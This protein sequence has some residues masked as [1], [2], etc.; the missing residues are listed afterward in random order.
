MNT[1]ATAAAPVATCTGAAIL[2]DHL[3]WSGVQTYSQCAPRPERAMLALMQSRRAIIGYKDGKPE[4]YCLLLQGTEARPG[5]I[6]GAVERETTFR[7]AYGLFPAIRKHWKPDGT[8][9][10]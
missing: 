5:K 6:Q 9:K 10:D 2:P 1:T 7:E 8:A 4:S 3:S